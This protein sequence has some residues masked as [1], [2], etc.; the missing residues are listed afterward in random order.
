MVAKFQSLKKVPLMGHFF[1]L[2]CI[3][4]LS[5]G[6]PLIASLDQLRRLIPRRNW[7]QAI[8]NYFH[9][10]KKRCCGLKLQLSFCGCTES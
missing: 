6:L 1:W 8:V 7:L 2:I 9:L 3:H 10:T 5:P 4:L